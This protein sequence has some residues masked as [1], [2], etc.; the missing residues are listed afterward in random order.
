M[1][2]GSTWPLF[3]FKSQSK[4][5]VKPAGLWKNVVHNIF[6]PLCWKVLKLDTV[7]VL[8]WPLLMF[9]SHGERTGSNC[10]YMY[11]YECCSL[12]IFWSICLKIAK[13][14]TVGAPR[15]WM[16]PGDVQGNRFHDQRW[17]QTVG[18]K[19]KCCLLIILWLWPQD[20]I[21]RVFDMTLC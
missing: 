16:F 12:S 8:R 5:K 7:D 18:L 14:G 21:Y 4:V 10:W 17:S 11:L 9:R 1:P 6:W 19:L 13:P 15:E 20:Q 2:L 3:I